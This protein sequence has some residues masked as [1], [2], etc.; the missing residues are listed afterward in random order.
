MVLPLPT[1]HGAAGVAGGVPR[2][3]A[4]DPGRGADTRD[5]PAAATSRLSSARRSAARGGPPRWP[6]QRRAAHDPD[7]WRDPVERD[8]DGERCCREDIGRLDDRLVLTVARPGPCACRRPTRRVRAPG[9]SGPE[10]GVAIHWRRRAGRGRARR[11]APRGAKREREP[12][13]AGR[14]RSARTTAGR[15]TRARE[16]ARHD[17]AP[18]PRPSGPPVACASSCTR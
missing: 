13:G 6:D 17:T 8:R 10:N 16:R 15:A 14:R 5:S 7:P 18:S 4:D 12:V 11:P 1:G 2:D 3:D 9:S